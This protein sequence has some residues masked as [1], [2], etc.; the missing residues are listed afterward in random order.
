MDRVRVKICGIGSRAEARSAIDSGADALGFNFWPQSPRYIDP[1]D[2]A[3]IIRALPPLVACI[4]VFVNENVDR[5][6]EI[7]ER[8]GLAGA[9]LHGDESPAFCDSLEGIRVIKAFRV[10]ADFDPKVI[11]AYRVSAALLDSKTPG[12]GG[13]G[14]GFDWQV[15]LNAKRYGPVIL[16]GGLNSDNVSEAITTVEPLA[17]DVC[18]GVESEPGRKDFKK[19]QAFMNAVSRANA[20]LAA[21]AEEQLSR[22]G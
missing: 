21:A 20:R 22:Q 3:D 14:K 7:T 4:G 13:S 1:G 8:S 11:Q 9:Q 19:M 18:S 12:Y 6:R 17:V 15:A 5:I 10:G 2:A 16:A